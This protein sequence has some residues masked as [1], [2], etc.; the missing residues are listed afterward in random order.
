MAKKEDP[1]KKKYKDIDKYLSNFSS[2]ASTTSVNK[3]PILSSAKIKQ[4]VK[5][6]ENEEAAKKLLKSNPSLGFKGNVPEPDKVDYRYTNSQSKSYSGNPNMAF[7]RAGKTGAAGKLAE[8]NFNIETLGA[9]LPL[10]G[11]VGR[12]GKAVIETS[13]ASGALSNAHKLNPLSKTH[14]SFNNPN[15]FYRQV[16]NETFKEGIKS[17]LIKGKQNVD[18]TKGEKIIN[19]NKSFGNDAYYKKGSLYSPQ[20][21]DYIYE[22]KK[23]EESFIPK[24][25]NRTRGY[26]AE[27]TPIRVSKEPIPLTEADVY[28][29]DWLQGYKKLET[30]KVNQ[31]FKSE[32]NWGKWNKEIP[33]NK[34]LL[35]EYKAIEQQTKANGNWMKNTD[36]SAFQGTP[37][38]FVQQN[39]ENFK[40]AFPQGFITGYRGGRQHVN[41]F[42]NRDLNDRTATFLTDSKKNAE[43]YAGSDGLEK[44]YYHP[45]VNVHPSYDPTNKSLP[46]NY[47]DGIY[48]LGFPQ[49]SKKV[50]AEANGNN[51]RFL[52]Y[53]K[54]IDPDKFRTELN[55]SN[56]EYNLNDKKQYRFDYPEDFN[57][58]KDYIS[59]DDYAA[60]IKNSNNP[61]GIAQINN[62]KDQM[63]YAE[64]IPS[65]TVYAI[66]ANK[67]PI[68]SLR[69]NNGMFDITNPNIYKAVVPAAVGGGTLMQTQDNSKQ[70]YGTGGL[71]NNNNNNSMINKYKGDSHFDPSGGIGLST[72]I[73]EDGELEYKGYIFSKDSE[74]KKKLEKEQ[75]L[76]AIRTNKDDNYV[77][78]KISR[79]SL[80]RA[81]IPLVESHE[82]KRMNKLMADLDMAEQGLAEAGVSSQEDMM[83]D[84]SQMGQLPIMA[85]GG[86]APRITTNQQYDNNFGM[87][88]SMLNPSGL[89]SNLSATS[90]FRPDARFSPGFKPSSDPT[91]ANPQRYSGIVSGGKKEGSGM[92]A[93]EVGGYAAAA[94]N[95]A[96]T[97]GELG[98]DDPYAKVGLGEKDQ[99][100]QIAESSTD[101]VVS[102]IP[103]VGQF[104]GAGKGLSSGAE[105]VRDEARAQGEDEAA[106]AWAYMGGTIDP[107]GS[108]FDLK[109]DLDKG[110]EGTTGAA[111]ANVFLPGLGDAIME[112]NRRRWAEQQKKKQ[113]NKLF[114][115]NRD[116]GGTEMA[117]VTARDRQAMGYGGFKENKQ[118]MAC[119]GRKKM[120]EGGFNDVPKIKNYSTR[121]NNPDYTS[122]P[123]NDLM[124]PPIQPQWMND[125]SSKPS[126]SVLGTATGP[127]TPMSMIGSSGRNNKVDW[128]NIAETA[129]MGLLGNVGNIAFLA[130]QGKKYDKVNYGSY[131]PERVNT[132]SSRRAIRDSIA[133]AKEGLKESGRLDRASMVMLG[134]QGAKQ[135]ADAEERV[136]L[137]NTGMFNDAQLKN[138]DI[139]MRQQ[140]D[141]AMNKGQALT[142]Y[143]NALNALGQNTQAA[144]R[145]YNLRTSDAEKQRLV[146]E[147]N[148]RL[149]E[150]IASLA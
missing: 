79:D 46:L 63:G 114:L 48:Q 126:Y 65:N 33:S 39:S 129:G 150:W 120:A 22:V 23:G 81:A 147:N 145:G 17:K 130:D 94:G 45:D 71:M 74:E 138:M 8:D 43:T 84:Q 112:P 44:T 108:W 29:K 142:N 143:Y 101:A 96:S 92:S 42:A 11:R 61:E 2:T 110:V 72:A 119:G 68:K 20:R 100:T 80:N 31:N 52:D 9:M 10:A 122:V 13:K 51:W 117:A 98:S 99:G 88:S 135:L 32:I 35:N 139:N 57:I 89:N 85:A 115:D 14:K 70:Q 141:E 82:E 40:K 53:N 60:Y 37:E 93:G 67:V 149:K 56:F 28:K 30:P 36:G 86:L 38:Q 97:L 116:F 75:A 73:V 113:E 104:Y 59:T 95:L 148:A 144:G 25:N 7:A 54:K 34:V 55:R 49:N 21:A 5:K 76:R 78:D 146:N 105:A 91:L 69:Y 121:E 19:L 137:A 12:A 131:T 18:K 58:N 111:I 132:S 136:R 6:V 66:D 106:Q 15:S 103:F 16:D 27:N 26:T 50:I 41:D 24:V 128:G 133:T 124:G 3:S 1:P 123:T 140:N 125:L 127:N 47:E 64:G 118:I 87:E 77:S 134:T 83:G 62:V 4:D 109:S 102:A 107:M 90:N